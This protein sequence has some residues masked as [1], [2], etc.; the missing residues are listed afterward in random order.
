M[1]DILAKASAAGFKI[2]SQ[3]SR[4]T[5][6]AWSTHA[7]VSP[8]LFPFFRSFAMPEQKRHPCH[9]LLFC[10]VHTHARNNKE[11]RIGDDGSN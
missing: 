5:A 3:N 6:P 9:A 2:Y 8:L 1:E 10:K 11:R 7:S 4:I